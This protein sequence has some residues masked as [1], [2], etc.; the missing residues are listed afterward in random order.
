M[1]QQKLF[2]RFR[3]L[4]LDVITRLLWEDLIFDLLADDLTGK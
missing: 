3:C 1:P 4:D 2:D